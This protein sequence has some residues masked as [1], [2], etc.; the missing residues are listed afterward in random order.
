[1]SSASRL[2]AVERGLG[3]GDDLLALEQGHGHGADI[4]PC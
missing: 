3:A 2:R 1:V 4:S